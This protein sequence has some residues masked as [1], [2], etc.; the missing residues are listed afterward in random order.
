MPNP[1]ITFVSYSLQMK[2][3]LSKIINDPNIHARWV[4]TL[5][6]MENSGARKIAA[7]EHPIL[8]KE[9]I[10][11]HA[12]EEFRH[13]YYLKTQIHRITNN[14]LPSYSYDSTLGGLSSRYYLHS[15]DLQTTKFLRNE[16]NLTGFEL[17]S[18]AYI[19]VTYAIELRA[20]ELY[21]I[22]NDLLKDTQN[23]ITIKSIL[24][25]EMGHLSEMDSELALISDG[26]KL[27][28]KA[29]SIESVLC[30]NLMTALASFL[31][32]TPAPC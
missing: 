19:L 24:V 15:L 13:A 7:S 9:E 32:E 26:K 25:E 28:E 17:R 20:L 10:L 18:T 8:V 16:Y 4:N 3:L 21:T 31:E 14:F 12:F 30:Y 27:L 22:Y 1:P 23:P 5:S 2:S 6:Y 29:C 11:K